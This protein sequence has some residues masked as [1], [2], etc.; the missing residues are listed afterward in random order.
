[1]ILSKLHKKRTH[2]PFLIGEFVANPVDY[3]TTAFMHPI[4]KSGCILHPLF[5]NERRIDPIN[6]FLVQHRAAAYRAD[7]VDHIVHCG[8]EVIVHHNV[9]ISV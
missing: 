8:I 5:L 9:V 3:D 1:M 2:Q 4:E 6:Q 7:D